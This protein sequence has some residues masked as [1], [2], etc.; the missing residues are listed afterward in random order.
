MQQS[1]VTS[2]F[3]VYARLQN[4][5]LL[6]KA[7]TSVS[8]GRDTW[9]T[10]MFTPMAVVLHASG[11]DQ[12]STAGGSVPN[13]LFSEYRLFC[14]GG[15]AGGGAAEDAS[16]GLFPP[17]AED[18]QQPGQM[19]VCQFMVHVRSL[20]DALT[21]SSGATTGTAQTVLTFP[22]SDGRLLVEQSESAAAGVSG[23]AKRSQC[24][25]VTRPIRERVLD[26]HFQDALISHR[27]SLRGDFARELLSDLVAFQCEQVRLRFKP[28]GDVIVEGVNS[29]FGSCAFTLPKGMD[30]VLGSVCGDSAIEGRYLLSHFAL[31]VLGGAGGT[32][33]SIRTGGGYG[34]GGSA[35]APS[36]KG[37]AEPTPITDLIAF[38]RLTFN[39]NT[40]RQLC[41]MHRARDHDIQVRV[42]VVIAPVSLM[43]DDII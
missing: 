9:A 26:L 30:G 3:G 14:I 15:Q 24:S 18:A 21:L 42:D 1:P 32:G 17:S 10:L 6:I 12:S 13:E 22:A 36:G 31:A 5:S 8:V 37:G 20:I 19:Q 16:G 38:S 40:E 25:L 4:V 41:V 39:V 7:L 34:L 29:P 43:L 2:T 33:K 35:G 28:S 23:G 27:L 11:D